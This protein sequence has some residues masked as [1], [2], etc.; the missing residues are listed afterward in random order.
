MSNQRIYGTARW[1]LVR[2]VV[3]ARDGWRCRKC[4]K[5]GRLE[6]D[7]IVPLHKGCDPWARDNLQVLCRSCH[8]KK[9][10]SENKCPDERDPGWLALV[11]DA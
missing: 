9:T 4:G 5:P 10:A 3:L 7:H 11:H 8:F 2:K 1:R 6:V